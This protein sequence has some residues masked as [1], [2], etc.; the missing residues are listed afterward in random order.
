MAIDCLNRHLLTSRIPP[1]HF[2]DCRTFWKPMQSQL[3][4]Q[5]GDLTVSPCLVGSWGENSGEDQHS[6]HGPPGQHLSSFKAGARGKNKKR[7]TK[8]DI[9]KRNGAKENE[10]NTLSSDRWKRLKNTCNWW[11]S[12]KAERRAEPCWEVLIQDHKMIQKATRI[13]MV[14]LKGLG[15][16]EWNLLWSQT[17]SEFKYGSCVV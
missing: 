13:N 16:R 11:K 3:R 14:T 15:P 8:R 1:R 9:Q 4:F 12:S 2:Q 5:P 17:R 7:E 10:T 6:L